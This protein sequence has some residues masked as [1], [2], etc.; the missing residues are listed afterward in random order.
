M[1]V[2]IMTRT[3]YYS[4]IISDTRE[5]YEADPPYSDG[6]IKLRYIPNMG[7]IA[8]AGWADFLE[9][10]KE[11]VIK[12]RRIEHI[13]E[14]VEIFDSTVEKGKHDFPETEGMIVNSFI[15]VTWLGEGDKKTEFYSAL[16][17][18][19]YYEKNGDN[20]MVIDK[21]DIRIIYPVDLVEKDDLIHNIV[22]QAAGKK[23]TNLSV[24]QSLFEMLRL[25]EQVSKNSGM[26]SRDCQI[27]IQYHSK[28][29][30]HIHTEGLFGNG[31]RL[32]N[33]AQQNKILRKFKAAETLW[34]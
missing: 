5:N 7:F 18:E 25:F 2:I 27:G 21:G 24:N 3:D 11:R 6:I 16:L 32:L 28:I 26:V 31:E 23:T 4:I 17:S 34:N 1:T 15:V 19:S 14:V 22:E 20:S 33:L 30:D 8:G 29:T 12:K 10:V 9:E 13:D